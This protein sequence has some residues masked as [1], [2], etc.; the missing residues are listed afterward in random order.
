M[1]TDQESP[2]PELRLLSGIDDDIVDFG[3]VMSPCD[4][5]HLFGCRGCLETREERVGQPGKA[6]AC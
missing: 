5:S 3:N 2:V 6:S 4:C 1:R